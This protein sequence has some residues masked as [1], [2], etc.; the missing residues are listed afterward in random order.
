PTADA[1]NALLREWG[2]LDQSSQEGSLV[3]SGQVRRENDLPFKGG[4]VR[5]FHESERSAIR[6][7]EDT[8]DA[9]GR[10]T[11]RYEMLS[12]VLSINLRVEAYDKDGTRLQSSELIDDAKP[13]E[14][15]NLVV[16]VTSR[17]F[18][19]R[20]LEGRVVFDNGLPAEQLTLRLYRLDFGGVET[21]HLSETTTRELG[22]YILPFDHSGEAAGL[23]VRAV[24]ATGDE[25]PLS[26][27]MY[28]L[29][30]EARV[31]VNLVA[32]AA[33]Q[34]L[35]AEYQRLATDLTPH[36]GEMSALAGARENAERQD[37]TVLNRA[38]GW[39][40]RLI[41]LAANAEKLSA[42]PDVQLP[43]EAVYGLLRAGLPSD[44]L[45]LAQVK[46][47]VVE[48]ALA[49]VREAG[50]VAL[51]QTPVAEVKTQFE[52][53][54]NKTRLAVPAPGS[55]STYG[56]LLVKSGLDE[57]AR[58]KFASVY[59]NHS[60]SA[61]LWKAARDAGLEQGQIQTLQLQGKLAFLAGNS[62]AMT[63]RLQQSMGIS[64]PVQ[65]V[66]KDLF[67]VTEWVPEIK[68]QADEWAV[69][70]K[71][72]VG[73]DE[74]TLDASI[75]PAYTGDTVEERLNAY[76]L[77]TVIPSAYAGETI[78]ERLNAYAEDM[79]RKVRLSYPTQ[80]LGRSIEQDDADKFKLGEAQARSAT[81]AL[82]KNA[83]A[84]GF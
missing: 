69:E 64:D 40:A 25:T 70:F 84:E 14:I 21:P 81:A 42:D 33:L 5:A 7:G 16:P 62:E 55:S 41:A 71:T 26:K 13:L 4:L 18:E 59:L 67:R 17:A 15:V 76:A 29:G 19:Q 6:L 1:I 10:Y 11:I 75:P 49:K 3:V 82:L 44:K 20:R 79:A 56:D 57:E 35:N 68:A 58:K 32:P 22:L 73:Q 72:R 27:P 52:T 37:L 61:D 34:S 47:E 45:Q 48:Q 24:D 9:E 83:A 66:D 2:L 60:R 31:V 39:D 51:E 28:D 46:P 53:F 77:D 80:V 50:I 36:V 54:A 43:Q 74:E 8:T 30:D 12:R 63:T 65:L 78:E 38:T 23:E